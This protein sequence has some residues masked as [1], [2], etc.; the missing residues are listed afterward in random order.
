MIQVQLKLRPTKAQI[1]E[2]ERY[3]V[4]LQSVYNWALRKLE[5]EENGGIYYSLNKFRNILAGTGPR[6]EVASCPIQ[7]TLTQAYRAWADYKKGIR[8]KPHL[9]SKRN[10][11]N[12]IPVP[13]IVHYLKN[14][15][16]GILGLGRIR[17]H[18]QEI[19]LGVV[20]TCRV[21]KRAS[22]WYAAITIDTEPAYIPHVADG[23]IGVDPGFKALL[24][25]S[26]G[27][28]VEHPRERE[29]AENRIA[30]AMRGKD[31]K[32]V[33]RL[34]EREKNRR[35][36][37]NHKLSRRLVSE[38]AEIYFSKD[39][40]KGLQRMGKMGKSVTSSSHYQLRQML[41][42]KCASSGRLYQEVDSKYS[43]MTCSNCGQRTGPTGWSGL[44]VRQWVCSACGAE[45]DRDVN[46]ARNTL[47][48]GAGL[49][50]ELCREVQPETAL[51]GDHLLVI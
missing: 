15:R 10:K 20:K 16:I 1:A 18:K 26:D 39:N 24:T 45:H 17:F 32:L 34:F 35:K 25:T 23:V 2:M 12:S 51:C 48:V 9:K 29:A 38:N 28:I 43:T 50:H 4:H 47:I 7:G 14:G 36:D 11:F 46:A 44:A 6:I 49:A 3:L 27:E 41:A 42:Y 37:R 8:K 19:P 13:E 21:L 22:G 5:L 30:Q 33:G 31:Y 40:L